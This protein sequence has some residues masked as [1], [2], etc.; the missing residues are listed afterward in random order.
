M[1]KYLVVWRGFDDVTQSEVETD[2]LPESLGD[3]DWLKLA[4]VAEGFDADEQEAVWSDGW[5][6]YLVVPM[7]TTFYA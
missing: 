1:E 6:L 3:Q 7:P 5:E 2:C 4:M